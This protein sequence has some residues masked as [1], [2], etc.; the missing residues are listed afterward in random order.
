MNFKRFARARHGPVE[1]SS[2]DLPAMTRKNH[3]KSPAAKIQTEPFPRTYKC[4]ASPLHGLT[5]SLVCRISG[6]PL[7]C[8]IPH[9]ALR[10][11]NK[12]KKIIKMESEMTG[13]EAR[14]KW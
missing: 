14:E 8:Y 5:P 10:M 3:E 7:H 1:A 9:L 6:P 12:K 4:I 11:L 2:R 13:M